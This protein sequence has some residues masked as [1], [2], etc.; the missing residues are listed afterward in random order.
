MPSTGDESL[1]QLDSEAPSLWSDTTKKKYL[2]AV[3]ELSVMLD[4]HA[5]LVSGRIGQSRELERYFDSAG[6]FRRILRGFADAEF[7]YCGSMPF[8]LLDWD[9]GDQDASD[10][11]TTADQGRG[12]AERMTLSFFQRQD[13]AVLDEAD[14]MLAGRRAYLEHADKDTM[15]DAELLI[16]TPESAALQ[17]ADLGHDSC[18]LD[19]VGGLE[20]QRS[21]TQVIMHHGEDDDFD[22][23]PFWIAVEDDEEE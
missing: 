21:V 19:E 23:D 11:S 9:D 8:A 6:E 20:R 18:P 22:G 15:E 16:G 12:S 2:Q 13:Y 14:L 5:E 4:R 3:R 1:G 7:E 10:E 17:V